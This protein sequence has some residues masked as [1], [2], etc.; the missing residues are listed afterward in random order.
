MKAKIEVSNDAGEV[1]TQYDVEYN[2]PKELHDILR[3]ARKNWL[4]SHIKAITPTH[5]ISFSH[6]YKESIS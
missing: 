4:E 2:K 3:D 1:V 6:T 5:N